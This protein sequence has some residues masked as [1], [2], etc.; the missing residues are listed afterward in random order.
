M[1][2][3]GGVIVNLQKDVKY[4]KGVGETRAKL[5]NNIG[6]Y[7]LEDLITYYPRNYQDR[8]NN[9]KL[10][11]VIDGETCLVQAIIVSRMSE[12]R[13]RKNLTLCK[14]IIRD[15]T[16]TATVT[17]FNQ[18][19]L[20]SR[21]NIGQEYKF[22][23]KISIKNGRID[24][25]NP[26]FDVQGENKNTGK[27]IPIYPL[28]YNLKQNTIRKIIENALKE[29]DGKLEETMPKYIL[30]EYKLLDTNSAIRKIHFPESFNDFEIAKKRLVFEELLSMQKEVN[31]IKVSSLIY[32]YIA[33]LSDATRRHDMIQLGVSPRGSLALCRMA[34]ASAFLAGRDYVVPEDVQDVVKD[35]FRHRLVLKSRARLSRKDVDKIMDEIC[36]TVHVP[37]RRAAGG[38]R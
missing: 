17:W 32:Q 8:N 29:V 26:T 6:I 15:E 1:Y 16:M 10:S 27:I 20:K 38:R 4:I 23:G 3:L 11:Q 14:M 28:T 36:A 25:L 19:F 7:T 22:Y 31:E 24:I 33:M 35:V 18:G 37:D 30:E 34:K 12:I 2:E 5:L 9:K 13:Y 21:F